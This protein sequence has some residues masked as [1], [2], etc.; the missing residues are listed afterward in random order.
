[1]DTAPRPLRWRTSSFSSNGTDCVEV[2][3]DLA[4]VRDS[5]NPNGPTL[6][7]DLSSIM[8]AIKVGYLER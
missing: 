1:M 6:R 8:V 2:F 4:A 5:K 7:V 3:H